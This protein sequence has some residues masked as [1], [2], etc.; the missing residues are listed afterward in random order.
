MNRK[1][2]KN[3]GS[4]AQQKKRRQEER[5][6]IFPTHTVVEV[7]PVERKTSDLIFGGWL[8]YCSKCFSQLRGN[9][10][11]KSDV[12]C[13]DRQTELVSNGF[14]LSRKRAWWNSW[15]HNEPKTA[16]SFLQNSGLSQD[17]VSQTL[18][19]Q[20]SSDSSK[21]WKARR[22][23]DGFQ[24]VGKKATKVKKPSKARQV[25]TKHKPELSKA[26]GA[27]WR[28]GGRRGVRI[29]EAQNPGPLQI[30]SV[31]IRGD[32]GAWDALKLAKQPDVWLLQETWLNDNKAN[33]FRCFAFSKGFVAYTQNGQPRAGNQ[34][35]G[36]GGVAVLVR[37]G[38]PQKFGAKFSKDDCQGLWVWVHGLFLG[39][40]YAA[41]HEHCPQTACC[42]F[43]DALVSA[44]V[45][46]SNKWF[47]GG[48]F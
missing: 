33:A 17:E 44:N 28:H 5:L 46:T 1:G 24:G 6:A 4:A 11:H 18:K 7:D 9:T 43:L 31:N 30:F 16:Q 19:L 34:V 21:R 26:Q 35:T 29:G 15:L 32:Q 27:S 36:S 40:I 48:D 42:G 8:Y 23:A 10:A 13:Q 47:L 45:K 2:L 20:N 41:P 37:R 25:A 3:P 38:L 12:S 14:V 22:A 39:S